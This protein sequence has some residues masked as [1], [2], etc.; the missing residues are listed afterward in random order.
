MKVRIANDGDGCKKKQDKMQSRRRWCR[1]APPD[2]HRLIP[3]R[4][5]P[6]L[7]PHRLVPRR[8]AVSFYAENNLVP[9]AVSVVPMKVE[10]KIL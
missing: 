5:F 3:H 7:G 6:P 4:L 2:S 8:G 1:F 9:S 10:S